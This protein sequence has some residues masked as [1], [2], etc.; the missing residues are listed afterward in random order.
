MRVSGCGSRNTA[1]GRIRLELPHQNACN[2]LQCNGFG[3]FRRSWFPQTSPQRRS[4]TT[5]DNKNPPGPQNPAVILI[6]RCSGR[7][8]DLLEPF[9]NG[10]G[11]LSPDSQRDLAGRGDIQIDVAGRDYPKTSPKNPNRSKCKIG[12]LWV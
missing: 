1:G 11:G 4:D 6:L 2:S 10:E 5:W 9:G 3:G 12:I 7:S 8:C